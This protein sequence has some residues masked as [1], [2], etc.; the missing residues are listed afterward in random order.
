MISK[1]LKNIVIEIFHGDIT[2]AA[3][4]ILVNAANNSLY[5]GSGVAGALKMA[6]GQEIEK[7]AIA[8]GPIQV[9]WAVETTAGTLNA[10]YVIHAAV[11]GT[12]LKTNV[13]NIGVATWNALALA[14]KLK[15]GSIAFPAL[16]TGVGNFPIDSSAQ[17]MFA[18]IEKF[19]EAGPRHIKRVVFVLYT[20]KAYDEYEKVFRLF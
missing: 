9:G 20:Q 17:L 12:D 16:G 14:E 8:K 19:D 6:G 15:M 2:K 7:E 5:M 11:M 1:K 4:D 18:I 3:A 10:R 13:K